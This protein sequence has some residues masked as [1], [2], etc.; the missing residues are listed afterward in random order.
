MATLI[1]RLAGYTGAVH[2]LRMLGHVNFVL[3]PISK[4]CAGHALG[5]SMDS[6]SRSDR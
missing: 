1:E 4:R 3:P 5:R 2:V 6:F